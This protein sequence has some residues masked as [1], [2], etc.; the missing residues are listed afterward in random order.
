M[1]EDDQGSGNTP[2]LGQEEVEGPR[3]GAGVHRFENNSGV[4]QHAPVSLRNKLHAFTTSQEQDFDTVRCSDQVREVVFL[5]IIER[6][7]RPCHGPLG[8][9][10]NRTVEDLSRN[11]KPTGPISFHDLIGGP[12]SG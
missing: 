11:A 3:R 9:H 5:K 4:A 6:S 2:I 8:K 10:Q 7:N 1:G 12:L